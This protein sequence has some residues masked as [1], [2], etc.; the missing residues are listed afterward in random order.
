MSQAITITL[1]DT[2]YHQLQRTAEI[3]QKPIEAIVVQSLSHSLP[4]L[5][6]D[7]PPEYQ[8]DVYPLL[9]M[10]ESALQR[11]V[12]RLFEPTLW[13]EYEALLDKKRNQPLTSREQLRLNKLRREADVLMFRKGYAAVLLKRR[14]YAVP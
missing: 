8:S 2:L 6:E 11:E 10:S 14:G 1:S 12:R 9:E 4:A 3:A 5:L 7:V 13:E